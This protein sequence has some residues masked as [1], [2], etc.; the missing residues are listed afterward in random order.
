M[1]KEFNPDDFR[2][3][4]GTVNQDG[5]RNWIYPIKPKGKFYNARTVLSLFYLVVLFVIPFIKID[6][7][8]FILLNVIDRKFILFGQIFWPQDFVIFAIV[9]IT[10]IVF[11]ALFTVAFGRLFCGWVCPQTIFME[12]V[13][14]KIEY[15]FE[16]DSMKQQK[17][18]KMP[19]N[20]EKIL[21]RGGKNVVF[22][23][24]SFL[25]ANVF[26]SY[27]IGMDELINIVTGSFKEH[28][29]GFV[30]IVVFASIFFFVFAWF[31]EQ[32]CIMVCPYG[33]LQGVL[34]D[35]DSVVVAYDH[36]RGEDRA[37]L[38]KGE[39]RTAGDCI[40]CKQ[41]VRVCPT[42]ID[43][44][45]GTQLECVN[46][47]ACIDVCDDIMDR[48]GFDRGLIKYASENSISSGKKLGFTPRLKAYT[49][50][51]II[52]L[53]VIVTL[54]ASREDIETNI[55]KTR[56]TVYQTRE[57]GDFT[58]LYDVTFINKTY[59]EHNLRLEIE[60]EN[61]QLEMVSEMNQLKPES[62]LNN[63]FFIVI[64]KAHRN[65]AQG[66]INI[67]IYK[68]DELLGKEKVKFY[69]PEYLK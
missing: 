12:M 49:G 54:L 9:M 38:R 47:T 56:G 15:W 40:D 41:C 30:S 27:I 52:L 23:L 64:P 6:G 63:K 26:L 57:N 5:K 58:N 31:R 17:L 16:G 22:W 4:I 8:P 53:G 66:K 42:G 46:C 50:V 61:I 20:S 24:I 43:I 2:D 1:S 59:N 51:L 55:I 7:H 60:D 37:K 28:V 14:R 65:K 25:I 62:K 32:V 39:E 29:G 10:L 48:V 13:F 3:H 67:N 45:N 36:K 11:I 69:L 68:G 21:K 44:R 18:T 35:K 19:W 33:R 34:L